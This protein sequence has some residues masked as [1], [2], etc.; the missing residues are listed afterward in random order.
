[1]GSL[2]DIV[3]EFQQIY[4]IMADPEVDEQIIADTLEGLTG[5][6]EVKAEGYCKVIRMLNAEA[7]ALDQ[8]A[9]FF[10]KKADVRK[11]NAKRMKEALCS[12]MIATGHD[13]KEGLKAGNFTLKV[14][15]NGGKQPL[16]ITGDVPENML[17]TIKEPDQDLI[18]EYLAENECDWAHLEERGK[19][20]AI[21]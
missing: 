10:K 15:G 19:H 6:L 11:N 5:E 13:G 9:Q 20:L 2:Y 4:E 14:Q 3:G 18:R 8:E 17:R 21:K 12:A 16:M 1:M 7:E